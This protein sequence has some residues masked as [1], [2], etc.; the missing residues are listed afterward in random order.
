MNYSDSMKAIL[1]ATI[2]ELAQDPEKYA[3]K[4]GVDFTRNRK[5][6]PESVK[7]ILFNSQPVQTG[8]LHDK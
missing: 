2:N 1:L 6:G 4:P 5:L 8:W 3:V 7:F